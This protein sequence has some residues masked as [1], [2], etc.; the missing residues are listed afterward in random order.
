MDST[1]VVRTGWRRV[2][3][4]LL[5]L[6]LVGMAY[7]GVLLPGIPAT[8]FLLGASYCFV[9]SSPRL[10]RWLRR[11]PVFGRILH[12]WEVHRGVRRPVKVLAVSMVVLVVTT[13][14]VF[15]SLKPWIKV[16]I[17][18]LAGVGITVILCLPTVQ[19]G[20]KSPPPGGAVG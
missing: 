9:R 8:P 16:V 12:D 7:L 18:C 14:I 6:A 20:P 11:S 4:V 13:S 2:G 17:G 3:L 10:H 15:T 1:P 19:E 5:G